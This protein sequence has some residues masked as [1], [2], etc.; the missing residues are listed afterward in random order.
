MLTWVCL[1]CSPH[2]RGS[3]DGRG[4]PP[5][6]GTTLP[7]APAQQSPSHCAAAPTPGWALDIHRV[8]PEGHTDHRP[9]GWETSP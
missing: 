6:L 3:W 7:A 2:C 8:R 5:A 9:L 1:L 4:G